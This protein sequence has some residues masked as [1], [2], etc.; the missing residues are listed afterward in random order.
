MNNNKF[1]NNTRLTLSLLVFFV[2]FY[3]GI[4]MSYARPLWQDELYSLKTILERDLIQILL[5]PFFYLSNEG[6]DSPVFYVIQKCWIL[7]LQNTPFAISTTNGELNISTAYAGAALRAPWIFCFSAA[8]SCL[9][10]YFHRFYGLIYAVL[11]LVVFFSTP[12]VFSIWAE[13]RPYALW[14]FLSTLHSLFLLQIL[15]A[16]EKSLKFLVTLA[17][18]HWIFSFTIFLSVIQIFGALLVYLYSVKRKSW[19]EILLIFVGPI[20][21]CMVYY[22]VAQ[23]IYHYHLIHP[24]NVLFGN[25][26]KSRIVILLMATIFAVYF[27]EMKS[28]PFI[29]FVWLMLTAGVAMILMIILKTDPNNLGYM[30]PTRYF[31]FMLVPGVILIVHQLSE[32][33]RA[34]AH[35]LFPGSAV[36]LICYQ[37]YRC[38]T[39]LS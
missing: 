37:L 3:L 34:K 5:T 22:L 15:N 6:N 11:A 25:L 20:F 8:V 38:I 26:Q 17:V 2:C 32:W 29:G 36:F 9:F 18:I 23:K 39:E 4:K 10:F 13:M 19:K 21:V 1:T 33:R 31:L 16:K 27:K 7:F 14:V 12:I 24:Q 35:F 30:F 28:L